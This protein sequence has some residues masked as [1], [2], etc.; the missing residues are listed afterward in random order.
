[1]WWESTVF[2]EVI[3]LGQNCELV[4]IHQSYHI[5]EV[6]VSEL[7]LRLSVFAAYISNI[8]YSTH[9]PLVPHTCHGELSHHYSGNGLSPVRCKAITWTNAASL[10]IGSFGTYFREIWIEMK[11]AF[12]K[13]AFESVV[14][15]MVANLL[16]RRWV[17]NRSA[18]IW[19]HIMSNHD[20]CW[21][22][23]AKM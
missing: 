9:L 1:M 4:V 15:E 3:I 8:R 13:N 7:Y 21:A 23:V 14:C 10:S 11:K 19:W 16:H 6:C 20:S 2:C 18:R 17:N 22:D 5:A 12:I